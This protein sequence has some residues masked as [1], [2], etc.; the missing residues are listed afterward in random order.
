MNNWTNPI[1]VTTF[2]EAKRIIQS[3]FT[4]TPRVFF[5]D[6]NLPIPES[7]TI[8]SLF[9]NLNDK[10]WYAIPAELR[11]SVAESC[12]IGV[13]SFVKKSTHFFR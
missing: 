5:A 8:N 3:D 11:Q 1:R 12:F 10:A 13:A 7:P 9:Y 4:A 6:A 2:S